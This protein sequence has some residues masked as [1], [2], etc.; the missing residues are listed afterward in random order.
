LGS[1]AGIALAG[2]LAEEMSENEHERMNAKK[3]VDR[4]QEEDNG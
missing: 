1:T 4:E 2:A 3:K